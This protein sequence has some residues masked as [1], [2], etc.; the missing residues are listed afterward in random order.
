MTPQDNLV[1]LVKHII[2][3]CKIFVSQ[4]NNNNNYLKKLLFASLFVSQAHAN[5]STLTSAASTD[6]GFSLML[7]LLIAGLIALVG[8]SIFSYSRLKRYQSAM[9]YSDQRLNFSLWAS[10]DEMWDWHIND[11]K[12]FRT[13]SKGTYKLS[14]VHPNLFPP[15]K[16]HIHPNDVNRVRLHLNSHLKGETDAFECAYRIK[17]KND[18]RWVLDKG[19]IVIRNDDGRPVRMTGIFKDIQQLKSAESELE[20]FAKSIDNLSEGVIILDPELNIIH[21]NPGYSKITGY[22]PDD[23]IGEKI[24]FTSLSTSLINEIKAKV[25]ATGIWRGD[26][27]GQHK[28]GEMFL[29]YITANCIKDEAGN[30][31]NYVAIVSDTTRRKTAEAKLRKMASTD[32]LTSLPNRNA[33]FDK[34]Q[35][36]V[37][38]KVPTAVLVFDLDN[39]KKINDSLG[40]Q[41]GDTLLVEIGKRIKPLTHNFNTLYRLGGDEF[42]FV[43]EKTNDIQKVTSAAKEILARLSKPFKIQKHEL[44]VAGSIGI[45]LYPDDGKQPE[46][47]LRNADTAM[48]HAKEGGNRYLFFS[49]DMN[50]QAVKRLQVENLI[51]LGL[52]ED[53]FQVYYQPKMSFETGKLV[54]MEALVRFVTPQKGVISPGTFIPIAEETGQIVEIGDLVLRKACIDMKRWVDQGLMDGRVAVNLSARQFN[55]PDLIQRIDEVLEETGLP[56]SNLELEITEGTVMDSPKGA[57]DTMYQLRDRGIHL[58]MDDFGTGYSSLSYLRK[59]PLNTLKID[60]AFVDDATSDIGKAMIDTII[61]IA[62]NLGLSTVAEG[63]ETVEQQRFMAEKNCDVLQGYLYSKPLSADEFARFARA[64]VTFDIVPPSLVPEKPMA[65]SRTA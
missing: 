35:D 14:K 47:L 53:Y 33:F 30:I 51:R 62:R 44:V 24:K 27:T 11:G 54:G 29:A 31:S 34:L 6:G 65:P 48:Y 63:V 32:S 43:M 50:K 28:Q 61:T 4:N 36:C 13:N 25:D 39:F 12:L 21:V 59:F 49:D 17:H 16:P 5:E 37:D 45:V 22:Q 9:R 23:V 38:R 20:V 55:L 19:R 41:L 26:I 60:K 7:A 3:S 46:T 40:H 42:A 8:I 57:I 52:K 56:S 1:I 18:W 10:G 2:R 15:N 58:A 64:E